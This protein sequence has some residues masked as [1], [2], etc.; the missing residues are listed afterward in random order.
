MSSKKK[1]NK[2]RKALN[3]KR[4]ERKRTV[5]KFLNRMAK[6]KEKA[7][8]KLNKENKEMENDVAALLQSLDTEVEEVE[9][10]LIID[11]REL[12]Q[13]N[14]KVKTTKRRSKKKDKLGARI[15]GKIVF[16]KGGRRRKKKTRKKRGGGKITNYD[17]IDDLDDKDG[18]C[19]SAYGRMLGLLEKKDFKM[20]EQIVRD[21]EYTLEKFK[22]LTNKNL[23][24]LIRFET[25]LHKFV[26]EI[27][28][29]QMRI[30]SLYCSRHGFKTYA[31]QSVFGKYFE[32]G[33]ETYNEMIKHFNTISKFDSYMKNK[34][35]YDWSRYKIRFKD[36]DGE[37]KFNQFLEAPQKLFGYGTY[38]INNNDDE[39]NYSI[40]KTLS[41]VQPQLKITHIFSY[42]VPGN[43]KGGK[44]R[45]KTRRKRGKRRRRTR[46][47]R[48]KRRK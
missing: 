34:M 26:I 38:D 23:F 45:K 18:E 20:T 4:Q 28:G 36:D 44:R 30:L 41:Y 7:M 42:Q 46:K 16:S 33:G 3:K 8:G 15:I 21:I 22:E 40:L 25:P 14:R 11:P 9:Q 47:K 39:Y 43:K 37:N 29:S 31:H 24:Y 2:K 13:I 12:S 1:L 5:K 10:P 27:N 48:K 6:E 19:H 17:L 35:E 32:I